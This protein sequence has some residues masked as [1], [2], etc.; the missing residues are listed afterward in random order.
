MGP[1]MDGAAL[2]FSFNETCKPSLEKIGDANVETALENLALNNSETSTEMLRKI[3]HSY[4]NADNEKYL[5]KWGSLFDS[6]EVSSRK[7]KPD[8][9]SEEGSLRSTDR[10]ARNNLLKRSFEEYKTAKETACGTQMYEPSLCHSRHPA[11][12]HSHTGEN[13]DE[14]PETTIKS[15]CYEPEWHNVQEKTTFNKYP[16][17]DHGGSPFRDLQNSNLAVPKSENNL[18]RL[19]NQIVHTTGSDPHS[20]DSYDNLEELKFFSVSRNSSFAPGTSKIFR[21]YSVKSLIRK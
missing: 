15:E 21:K 14:S 8:S 7:M 4:V 18:Q 11:S 20:P 9:H 16:R 10:V 13:F 2:E 17:T 12:R 19:I 6:A 3:S 5:E 1:Y